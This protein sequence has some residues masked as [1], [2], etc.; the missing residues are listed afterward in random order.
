MKRFLAF[1]TILVLICGLT[2]CSSSDLQYVKD[3]GT[4]VVGI[5][6]YHPM[7]IKT[8]E[9]EWI[10]FDADFAR[11]VAEELAL[12]VEFKSINWDEK[13]D[14]LN[15]KEID[16]I[17]NGYTINDVDNV[18][19]SVPYASNSQV[20]V[21]RGED[22]ENYTLADIDNM[23]IAIE[24]G[25]SAERLIKASRDSVKTFAT[26]KECLIAVSNKD[27]QGCVVDKVI[28]DSLVH[29]DLEIAM[30]LST[31]KFGIGFRK[32]SNITESVNSVIEKLK[33]NGTLDNLAKK[34]DIE[35]AE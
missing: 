5:T 20:L 15:N 13:V 24:K 33:E 30:T 25:S 34:Y 31:E 23:L 1:L 7:H 8:K 3:K 2:A 11:C 18:D 27:V 35:L 12:D 28:F 21:V 9:G 22:K 10:G 16:C 32:G 29:T 14:L 17:W 4:L 6:E 26:Q 19:F